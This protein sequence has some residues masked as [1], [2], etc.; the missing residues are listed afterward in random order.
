[1]EQTS[2]EQAIEQFFTY[3]SAIGDQA[4]IFKS[5]PVRVRTQKEIAYY[6]V[7]ASNINADGELIIKE[8]TPLRHTANATAFEKLCLKAG[9]IVLPYRSKILQAGL[10]H[11]S[12]YP[13]IPNPAL[14]V[15][16]CEEIAL[17]KFI[18]A[19]LQLPFI[20][21]YVERHLISKDSKHA[22]LDIAKFRELVIPATVEKST[23]ALLDVEK[24][25]HYATRA[26]EIN[27]E[28]TKLSI[29]LS[30]EAIS[31]EYKS[32]PVIYFKQIEA[33]LHQIESILDTMSQIM[34]DSPASKMLLSNFTNYTSDKL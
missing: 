18:L 26:S 20:R 11:S 7:G 34:I 21:S 30:A 24:Y 16:R 17:G 5:Y 23:Y 15:I 19:C 8:N 14:I 33:H 10:Y 1:M 4:E 28:L 2:Y 22:I 25:K 6:E 31:G 29:D 27:T 12:D 9:D 32:M 3:V 13:M